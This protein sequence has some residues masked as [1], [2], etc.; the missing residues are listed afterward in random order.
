MYW[1]YGKH[2]AHAALCNKKRTVHKVILTSEKEKASLPAIVH[3]RI[4]I[5]IEDKKTFDHLLGKDVVHQGIAVQVDP[6]PIEHLEHL[7]DA[8]NQIVV[9]LDQVS[10]PNNIGS[11]L[12]ACAAFGA[13][14]LI[15]PERHSPKE[16]ASL[17][18]TASGALEIVPQMR[19]GNLNQA[20][21]KLKKMGFWTVAFSEEAKIP[22][23]K[24]DL[25][26][27]IAL[28][29]GSEGDGIRR[30]VGENC[31]HH[32]FLE[33]ASFSTLNVATATAVALYETYNQQ[34]F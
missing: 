11:I 13:S 29:M 26:G 19:V 20:I 17:A 3:K 2:A 31:D 1:I 18:K 22:L 23:R 24:V 25:K 7:S 32:V 15:M 16:T 33:T 10:D 9:L 34:K 6:L 12:R 14:A 30:L 5:H 21:E 27:K 4:P 8:P 28:V